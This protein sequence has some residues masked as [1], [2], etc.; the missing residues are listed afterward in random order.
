MELLDSLGLVTTKQPVMVP[1]WQR[2]EDEIAFYKASSGK[3]EQ[4][5]ILALG[6]SVATEEDGLSA[7][8]TP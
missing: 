1:V 6:G 5:N 7:D 3:S 4:I 8:A 2:G